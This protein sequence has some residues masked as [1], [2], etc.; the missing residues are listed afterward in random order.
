MVQYIGNANGEL[1]FIFTEQWTESK[2]FAID[3]PS[4]D[5]QDYKQRI[6]LV[7]MGQRIPDLPTRVTSVHKLFATGLLIRPAW[8]L[9]NLEYQMRIDW[10][11]LG[12]PWVVNTL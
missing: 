11:R 10:Y 4:F 12:I 5:P 9:P 1:Q 2:V 6:G 7:I 8:P 3:L